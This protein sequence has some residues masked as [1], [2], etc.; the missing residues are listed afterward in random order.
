M[1]GIGVCVV[2]V[3]AMVFTIIGWM[4]ALPPETLIGTWHGEHRGRTI[5]LVCGADGRFAMSGGWG[6]SPANEPLH[7]RYLLH[8][9][10]HPQALSLSKLGGR[11][12]GLHGI[13]RF[14]DRDRLEL[15]DLAPHWKLRP[16][17]F[18][19]RSSIILRRQAR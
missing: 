1:Q 4:P 13:V 3:L 8:A 7:G 17:S 5:E 16:L 14:L 10:R 9:N 18:D 12:H 11:P 6:L 19:A 2:C 15:S